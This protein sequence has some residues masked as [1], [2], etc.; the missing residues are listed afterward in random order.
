MWQ[1]SST[2]AVPGISGNVDH[3]IFYGDMTA[4]LKFAKPETPPT[5]YLDH[6]GCDTVNGWGWDPDDKAT[7]TNVDVYFNGPAG[8]AGATGVRNLANISRQD[9]CTALGSC[10]HAFSMRWPRSLFDGAAHE[11]H[12]YALDL[13]GAAPG[14]LT[15]SPGMGNCAALSAPPGEIKRWI[16][17]PTTF[18]DWK[19]D[20]FQDVAPFADA[21]LAGVPD[22]ANVMGPPQC[23]QADD[24]TPEV[25]V[26]DQNLRRH[27]IDPDSLNA[28]RFTVTKTPAAQVYA[29][30]I[31]PDWP[32]TPDL[33]KASDPKVYVFD[34]PIP[35]PSGAS[36]GTM[37]TASNGAGGASS[38]TLAS[39][40]GG[41]GGGGA[42]GPS[43]SGC[44]C[45]TAGSDSSDGRLVFIGLAASVSML[46][47]VR[48]RYR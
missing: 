13:L 48:R 3:D 31:G 5:G 11:V 41:S 27:V 36:T 12:A 29:N 23:V 33:A 6:V 25:W 35:M 38:G 43:H 10:N 37:G 17:D 19:F 14:E 1:N 39:G 24:G 30:P 40:T 20:S 22:G 15:Q 4:F 7:P 18:M 28:W 16:T 8:A 9:L 21:V 42:S 47:R 26:I 45:T 32:A 2:T 44:K 46:R 34:V